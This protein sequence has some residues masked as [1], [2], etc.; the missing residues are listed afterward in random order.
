[1]LPVDTVVLNHL[2]SGM[3]I[4][5]AEWR[6]IRAGG[7]LILATR[8][9]FDLLSRRP[10]TEQELHRALARRFGDEAAAGAVERMRELGY[11]DDAA[12]AKQYVASGASA[13]RGKALLKHELRHRGVA[14][15]LVADALEG[16]DDHAAARQAALKRVRALRDLDPERRRR[17]LYDF[18][19]RRG[20][21]DAAA[22][23][24]MEAA[25]TTLDDDGTGDAADDLDRSVD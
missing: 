12:W 3:D 24:A 17:R 14:D 18:L 19:R 9:G 11:L 13:V 5:D 8:L 21:S 10:R 7:Q 6:R 23:P 1:V 22:R 2:R 25:L 4:E 15:P 16:H 20:F